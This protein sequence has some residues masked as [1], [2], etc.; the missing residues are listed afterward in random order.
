MISTVWDA[1]LTSPQQT[2]TECGGVVHSLSPQTKCFPQS[3]EIALFTDSLLVSAKR[4]KNASDFRRYFHLFKQN[5]PQTTRFKEFC[6]FLPDP[7]VLR[8][9]SAVKRRSVLGP[10][11]WGICLSQTHTVS[12]RSAGRLLQTLLQLTTMFSDSSSRQRPSGEDARV[13]S[14]VPASTNQS[15]VSLSP[16]QWE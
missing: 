14:E 13:S 10:L 12:L 4:V 5:S 2:L 3:I 1:S 6:Y 11:C 15:A 8:G 7:V 9:V 16:V